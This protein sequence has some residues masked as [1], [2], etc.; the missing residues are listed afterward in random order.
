MKINLR[1]LAMV[2]MLPPGVTLPSA[3]FAQGDTMNAVLAKLTAGIQK[4]ESSCGNDI[5]KY[6]KTVTRGGGRI[7]YCLQ[8]HDDKL[9]PKCAF[10]LDEA[11]SDIQSTV[12]QLKEA[13]NTCRGDIEKLCAK[14]APGEGRIA[15]CLAAN[16]AA[17]S[18]NC[19]EAVEKIQV[20]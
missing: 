17:V 18:Q 10:E 12:D 2:L 1:I 20:K 14:T 13:V 11:A 16:K 4:L 7:V 15:A 6:C 8:A 19:V 3:A 9:S 5:K